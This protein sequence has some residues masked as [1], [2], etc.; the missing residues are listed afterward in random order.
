MANRKNKFI[1]DAN[2][3]Y[4]QIHDYSKVNYI[5]AHTKVIISCK[6]HSFVF[7]QTPNGHLT[8]DKKNGGGRSGCKQCSLL[9][10]G[11]SRR[12][13]KEQFISEAVEIHGNTYDYTKVIYLSST[14][15]VTIICP[16]EG[17]GEFRQK[18]NNH[19]KGNKCPKCSGCYKP[20]TNEFIEK[21]VSIH[22]I[23]TYDYSKSKYVDCKTKVIIICPKDGHGQFEQTPSNHYLFGCSKCGYEKLSEYK[24][25]TTDEF[26]KRAIEKHGDKYDYKDTKYL[27]NNLDLNI[28][29]KTHGVFKQIAAVHLR[30]AGC[31][32]CSGCY[33][34]DT[35][36][37]IQESKKIHGE[38]TYDYSKVVYKTCKDYVTIVCPKEGHGPFEQTPD[39]HINNN[40]G[41]AKCHHERTALRM[42]DTQTDFLR[43]AVETH[44]NTYDYD[45]V[46]YVDSLTKVIIV[47]RVIG[48]GQFE[49]APSSHIQGAGCIKCSGTY[50]YDTNEFKKRAIEKHGENTYDYSKVEYVNCHNPVIIG[51]KE[52][53]YFTQVAGSHLSGRGCRKC[54]GSAPLNID[55]VLER[56]KE[57]HGDLYDYSKCEYINC[58]TDMTIT[59]RR[60]GD[61]YQTYDNHSRGAGCPSCVHKTESKLLEK[62]QSVYPTIARQFKATWCQKKTYLPFDFC[63]EEYKII[64]ELDG[65]QHFIPIAHWGSLPEQQFENDKFKETCANE[66]GYSIIRLIQEDVLND[67]YDWFGDL[68]KTISYTINLGSVLNSYLCKN[69]EYVRFT[70]TEY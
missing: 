47:C 52:H 19:L 55:I 5:N 20:D 36:E 58:S 35:D 43:K 37:F 27:R 7:E 6:I 64:I 17:H 46:N 69:N 57:K 15:D 23:G 44:G 38:N 18:P 49:Q 24:T 9:K 12:K 31:P 33:K 68:C 16:N 29:C 56:F 26:K 53:G 70:E 32:K 54:G 14:D 61:F 21:S 59:C 45:Q 67:K 11:L 65:A 22:G 62:L 66:N 60:H 1:A 48:H 34:R 25:L 10:I 63:I 50:Q 4:G 30:G 42:S 8:K 2:E 41:C 51:C 13:T 3:L 39:S 40:A 28:I